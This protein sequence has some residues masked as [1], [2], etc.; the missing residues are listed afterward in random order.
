MRYLSLKFPDHVKEWYPAE[1]AKKRARIDEY[2][3]FHHTNT[4][5]CGLLIFN[6]LFTKNLGI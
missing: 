5:R 1:N 6:T 2:L 4:R 3:D